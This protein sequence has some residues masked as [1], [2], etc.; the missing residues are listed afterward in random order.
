[1][2]IAALIL[3]ILGGL[4]GLG[5]AVFALG[6]GGVAS[7]LQMDQGKAVV[8]LG[9]AAIPLAILGVVGGAL[10]LARPKLA[11]VLMLV[12]AV[13]GTIAISAGYV[14]A[15]PLLAVGG[16]LALFS[17]DAGKAPGQATQG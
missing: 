6:V 10:A 5:G 2:R 7:A 16:L 9:F 1:M 13:G 15:A 11:G 12:S 8:G 4:F 17:R 3:G 14:I